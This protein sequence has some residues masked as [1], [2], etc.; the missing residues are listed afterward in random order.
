[1]KER[2]EIDERAWSQASPAAVYALLADGATWPSW[3]KISSFELQQPAPDGGE[4]V[5]AIRRFRTGRSVSVEEIVETVPGRRFSYTLLEGLPLTNYR[6]D[7]DLTES[8]GGTAIRWHSTFGAKRPG[9]G[10]FYRIV[11]GRF[12]RSCVRGLARAA[13]E[14]NTSTNVRS[15]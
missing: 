7:V 11:L 5:G 8:N 12:I 2:F 14:S 9:T 15:S 10:R 13:A 3:S 1:M 4:R 6:A